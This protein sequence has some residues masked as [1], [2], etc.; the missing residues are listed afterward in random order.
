MFLRTHYGY[1][2]L[3]KSATRNCAILD[4]MSSNMLPVYDFPSVIGELGTSERKMVSFVAPFNGYKNYVVRS[5]L[6][7]HRTDKLRITEGFRHLIRHAW[8]VTWNGQ[9]HSVI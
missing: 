9:K 7:R 4:K 8:W 5:R 3:V 1:D 6:L 2:Q